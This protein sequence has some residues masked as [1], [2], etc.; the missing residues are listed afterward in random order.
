MKGEGLRVDW[1][2]WSGGFD[3]LWGLWAEPHHPTNRCALVPPSSER[4]GSFG[5]WG[6]VAGFDLLWSLRSWF[7]H[8]TSRFALV[9]PSSERTVG[10]KG[11]GLRVKGRWVGM[12]GGESGFCGG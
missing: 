6:W 4:T 2:G 5:F 9:P 10:V 12:V 7:H 11:E 3:L 1:S 8:P